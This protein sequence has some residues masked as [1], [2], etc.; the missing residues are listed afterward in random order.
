MY[1]LPLYQSSGDTDINPVSTVA[2]ASQLIFGGI[3]KGQ[4]LS[5]TRGETINLVA[6]VL[7]GG[8]AAQASDMTG[9]LKTGHLIGAKPKHQ[10]VAQLCGATTSIFLNVGLFILFCKSAPCILYPDDYKTCTYGAPSVAAWAAVAQAVSAPVFPVPKE[11]GYTAIGLAIAA[12]LTVAV[13]HFYIPRQYWVYV[14]RCP[15]LVPLA[16]SVLT[17][18]CPPYSLT[19][20]PSVSVS[21]SPSRTTPS[22]WPLVPPSTT[23]GSV[24]RPS[25]SRCTALRSLL[26]SSLA[27]VS[28]VSST[29]S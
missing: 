1:A 10:F 19:G 15:L 12:A 27:R 23:S 3:G 7:S 18:P 22:P 29:L 16:R 17:N 8:S 2:K 24:A 5:V 28:V 14:V 11:S 9:D 21:S 25:L 20:T 13:K 4:H 26:A 6:G